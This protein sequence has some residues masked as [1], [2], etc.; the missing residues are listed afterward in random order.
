MEKMLFVIWTANKGIFTHVMMNVLDFK[1]KGYEVGVVFESDGCKHISEFESNTNEKFEKMK[2]LKLIFSVC[3][4]C[5]KGMGA[6]DSA[7]RQNLPIHDDLWG[8]TPLEKWVAEGFKIVS[9]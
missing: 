4:A 6:L 5:A 8:H 9:V 2:E 7:K 1:E 3:K